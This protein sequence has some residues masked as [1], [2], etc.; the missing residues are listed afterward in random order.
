MGLALHCHEVPGGLC[1]QLGH[2]SGRL[3][4]TTASSTFF[5]VAGLRTL[6]PGTQGNSSHDA[7]GGHLGE[8]KLCSVPQKTPVICVGSRVL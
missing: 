8:G 5:L 6:P 7:G 4:Q 2:P 3:A 1:I